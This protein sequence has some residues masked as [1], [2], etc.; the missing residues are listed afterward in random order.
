M[1]A[2]TSRR[3]TARL[4]A[5][6]ALFSLA[7]AGCQVG[8]V[9]DGEPV[10]DPVSTTQEAAD[11]A[12]TTAATTGAATEDAAGTGAP[13]DTDDAATTGG[14]A[15]AGPDDEGAT[16]GAD[17]TAAQD[18]GADATQDAGAGA[19][20]GIP[21]PGTEVEVGDTVTTHVRTIFEEGEEYYG[22][23]TLATTVLSVEQGD[24]SLFEQA[25]NSGDFAGFT[26]WYVTVRD[27]WLTFEG[28]PNGNMLPNV[29]AF[30]SQGGEVSPVINSTWSA[31]I[32]GCDL[33]FT[34]EPGAG[35]VATRCR[36]FAVPDG[37]AIG[38]VGWRGD[39]YADAD[40]ATGDNPYYDDPVLWLVP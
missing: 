32:P 30:N 8:V 2:S 25:S 19:T 9:D 21:A 28:N 40:E 15:A 27:E 7:L 36:V 11:A 31:G 10:A 12:P 6:G 1:N 16:A 29:V 17:A 24:R 13:A 35:E 3:T 34:G 20:D 23:A 18:A 22:Y 5:A 33:E 38:A 26:P 37:E 14:A 39:E 4:A